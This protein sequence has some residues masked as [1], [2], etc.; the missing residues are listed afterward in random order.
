[1]DWPEKKA[2][3]NN[4]AFVR[5]F[6][7]T[8][9]SKRSDNLQSKLS[10]VFRHERRADIKK[11]LSHEA[12]ARLECRANKA[13][14]LLWRA[15]PLTQEFAL[16]DDEMRFAVAY[17]TGQRL[18]HLPEHCSC[19]R[20]TQL[21]MEH[22]VHCQEKLTR[23]N[24]I[25]DRFVAFAHLHGVTIKQ[26][27]RLDYEDAKQRVEPDVI[28]YPG[29]HEDV[30][31]DITVIN[32]CA[33]HRMKGGAHKWATKSQK[34]RKMRKYLANARA[35]GDI[36]R[37]L[38]FETHGKMSE[39]IGLTLDML[40]SGTTMDRGMAVHD[41]KLDLAVTLARGNALAAKNTIAR[42][43]RARERR[44]AIHPLPPSKRQAFDRRSRNTN[45]SGGGGDA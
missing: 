33:P 35:R 29:V 34:A 16:S 11:T 14:S 31:T 1:V 3:T 21:T 26:N 37:P 40:A 10:A 18:P 27:P 22:T 19:G 45:D 44:R 30:Q 41:M 6:F 38:V 20:D 24:M 42:A 4:E 23:H 36:F 43:Q 2:L 12:K 8:D 5:H 17:A 7:N 15:Y 9:H 25:Q 13:T 32:P 28:F 39:E